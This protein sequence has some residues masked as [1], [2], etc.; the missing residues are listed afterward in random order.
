LSEINL[1]PVPPEKEAK[2]D[3]GTLGARWPK[4]ERLVESDPML[5][6]LEKGNAGS[7]TRGVK[8]L[9][10]PNYFLDEAGLYNLTATREIYLE[11]TQSHCRPH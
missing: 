5:R 10:W 9:Q 1:S 3:K 4:V 2:Q 8:Y 7:K 6:S 11:F